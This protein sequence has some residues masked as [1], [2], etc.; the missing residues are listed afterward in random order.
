MIITV[1]LTS[2][3]VGVKWRL[4][5]RLTSTCIAVEAI[6]AEAEVNTVFHDNLTANEIAPMNGLSAPTEESGVH[7]SCLPNNDDFFA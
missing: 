6:G 7:V 2:M 4:F 3:K 1:T 5:A